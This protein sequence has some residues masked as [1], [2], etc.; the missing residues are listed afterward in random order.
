MTPFSKIMTQ[1]SKSEVLTDR[2][3]LGRMIEYARAE[4]DREGQMICAEL[5]CAALLSLDSATAEPA[6]WCVEH[7]T[8]ASGVPS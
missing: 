8:P 1:L 5:L 4:A 7:M 2:E 6:S 3:A